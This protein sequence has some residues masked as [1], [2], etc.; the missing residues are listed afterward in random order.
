MKIYTKKGDQG[1]TSLIGGT[2]VPKSHLRIDCYGTVD[3][4]NSC[5]GVLCAMRIKDKKAK[6]TLDAVQERLF[7]VGSWL[8]CDPKTSKMTLPELDEKDV[9]L[10]EQEIDRMTALLPPLKFFI[11]PGGSAAGAWCHVVRTVCRRAER[12]VVALS[13]KDKVD[14]RIIVYLNR[15]SDYL[16]VLGRKINQDDRVPEVSWRPKR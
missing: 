3:E 7:V 6:V 4:L 2:K 5:L 14:Q 16:F 1:Y 8:A 11:L 9:T 15:L 13:A 10:L 12:L